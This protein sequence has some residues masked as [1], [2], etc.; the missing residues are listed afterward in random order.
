LKIPSQIGALTYINFSILLL[1]PFLLS[2]LAG[3]TEYGKYVSVLAFMAIA[4]AALVSRTFDAQLRFL[5]SG[6]LVSAK[7]HRDNEL[8]VILVICLMIL[9]IHAI[10]FTF[11]PLVLILTF[12]IIVQYRFSYLKAGFY[13][14]DDMLRLSKLELSNSLIALLIMG[15]IGKIYG[16]IGLAIGYL[17]S[18]II[19]LLLFHHNS[20]ISNIMERQTQLLPI[21]KFGLNVTLR[22]ISF[23]IYQNIDLMLVSFFLSDS[24]VAV[25]RLHKT[26]ANIPTKGVSIIWKINNS[27]IINYAFHRK[28]DDLWRII[29]ISWKVGLFFIL[30]AFF[31]LSIILAGQQLPLF[32]HL[33]QPFF[34]YEILMFLMVSGL[35]YGGLMGWA[36]L[37]S[38]TF[39]MKKQIIFMHVIAI[40][41]MV[42]LSSLGGEIND[43]AMYYASTSF[44][45]VI[46][47][48]CFAWK[49]SLKTE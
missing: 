44:A 48:T 5:K 41:L 28:R 9:I 19:K 14:N 22:Q 10:L 7:H 32:D 30:I 15:L 38:A 8:Y 1:T 33:D 20:V 45:L 12:A 42:V 3:L 35:F 6:N 24:M 39:E 25:Y 17:I 29:E 36:P 18:C 26:V 23:N 47:M 37:F 46:L 27:I 31:V 4:E 34:R 13:V 40:S 21:Q 43:L 49:I 2:F 11:S 16:A